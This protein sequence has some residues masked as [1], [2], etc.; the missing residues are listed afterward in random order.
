M[1]EG[2]GELSMAI[3]PELVLQRVQDLRAR[4]HRACPKGVHV[5]GVEVQ[6]GG[7]AAHGLRRDDVHLRE[8]VSHHH[9]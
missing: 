3:A 2:V 1:P 6:H 8:L 4:I 7:R 5:L 9:R